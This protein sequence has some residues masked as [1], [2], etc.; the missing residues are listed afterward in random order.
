MNGKKGRLATIWLL[1][2]VAVLICL[3]P[4]AASSDGSVS[5][6]FGVKDIV[7]PSS[8]NL[9]HDGV[10]YSTI[11]LTWTAPGDDGDDGTAATYEIRYSLSDID[12]NTAWNEA[13]PIMNPP[14][15][16]PAGMP[17]K[18]RIYGLEAC[19]TYYFAIMTAD[20]AGNWSER[21]DSVAAKTK[22][23]PIGGG[24]GS[25]P[26]EEKP[27]PEPEPPAPPV[28]PGPEAPP[29][30]TTPEASPPTTTTPESRQINIVC[31]LPLTIE[32]DPGMC[33]VSDLTIGTPAV[34]HH[35][36]VFAVTNDAPSIF[37]IGETVVTWSVTDING[38]TAT[39]TQQITVVEPERYIQFNMLGKVSEVK[40]V[41][42]DSSVAEASVVFDPDDI[43]SL[44]IQQGTRI[45]VSGPSKDD[46]DYPELIV[47]NASD[48][49]FTMP[50]G[51][52]R[53]TP[54]Y[55]FTGYLDRSN[56]D[57]P[58]ADISFD[59]PVIMLLSY[60][61]AELPAGAAS[62]FIASY[63]E[64]QEEWTRL[65]HTPG[66]VAEIGVV[67]GLT[68]HFSYFTVLVE[69]PAG[70]FT[71]NNLSVTMSEREI[72]IG[73]LVLAKKIGESAVV[74]AEI[75]GQ[76]QEEYDYTV[77]LELDGEKYDT[78]NIRLESGQSQE[79]AYQL[80]DIQPG[81]HVIR[82]ATQSSEFSTRTSVN[83]WLPTGV[84]VL[85]VLGFLAWYIRRRRYGLPVSGSG[86][87]NVTAAIV[88]KGED[89]V[90]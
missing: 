50:G 77:D 64:E 70:D 71:V 51:T 3:P 11:E 69:I 66:R 41:C 53:L 15:P 20:D 88:K 16:K 44:V 39:C 1:C 26:E 7:P 84:A 87:E 73:G 32:A 2:T 18:F 79:I 58:C 47:I 67:D 17:E 10:D 19:T 28:P 76:F 43:N 25:E 21:S 85:A 59:L 90:E 35:G 12:S 60:N 14:L 68:N 82:L 56:L 81:G 57:T 40:V 72:G 52:A 33:T 62:P 6:T 22:C 5:G 89:K 46:A 34:E 8:V 13:T 29:T 4:A 74:T 65:I 48:Q 80:V 27:E 38:E 49:A 55:E 42:P 9:T 63:D 24:W 45:V 61:P 75:T 23:R 83:W 36:D 37:P 30:T 31:P 78:I 54:V 86:T